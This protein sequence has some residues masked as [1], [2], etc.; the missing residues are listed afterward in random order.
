MPF[1]SC[2]LYL[3]LGPILGDTLGTSHMKMHKTLLAVQSSSILQ[4]FKFSHPFQPRNF[5]FLA[6]NLGSFQGKKRCL[7]SYYPFFS[8]FGEIL[9]LEPI[10]REMISFLIPSLES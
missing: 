8:S 2:S 10:V 7:R 1:F 6:D 9:F 4:T 5:L 3:E